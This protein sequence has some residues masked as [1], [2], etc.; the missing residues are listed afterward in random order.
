M[1]DLEIHQRGLLAILKNRCGAPN[2]P[3]LRQVAN[4]RELAMVLALWWIA[5][6]LEAQCRFTM[7][8]LKRLSSFDLLV[9]T[10]FDHNKTS[11]F[12][13]ELSLGFLGS[14][15]AHGDPLVRAVS[16]FEHALLTVRAGFAQAHEILWD[17]HPERVILALE[18][19]DQLPKREQDCVYRM[20]VAKDLP[21]M[22]VCV[23]ES[24][25]RWR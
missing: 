13:E 21:Q 19:G 18:T 7:R 23:R 24:K 10:Y 20:R 15:H 17:R 12:V 1:T 2:D 9:A 8:L 3:Y 16:E 25:G 11:P 6:A 5:F 22:L 4:S 14:L